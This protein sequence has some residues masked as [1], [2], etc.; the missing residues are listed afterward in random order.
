MDSGATATLSGLTISG[1]TTGGISNQ[2]TMTVTGSTIGGN[3]TAGNGAGILNSGN[4]TLNNSIVSGNTAGGFG[5]GIYNLGTLSLINSTLCNNTGPSGGGGL[6]NANNGN[7]TIENSII[8]GDIGSDWGN[9]GTAAVTYSDVNS[10]P[11]GGRKVC[12]PIPILY[13]TRI[14]LCRMDRPVL[15]RAITATWWRACP[16]LQERRASSAARWIWERTRIRELSP[17]STRQASVKP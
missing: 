15:T 7:A 3:T 5:G 4:L 10:G 8:Y 12:R 2:G 13:S 6:Y 14:L 16:T 17:W 1:G 9:M 11:T